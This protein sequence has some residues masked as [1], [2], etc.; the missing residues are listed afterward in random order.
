MQTRKVDFYPKDQSERLALVKKVAEVVNKVLRFET[1][2]DVKPNNVFAKAAHT[3]IFPSEVEYEDVIIIGDD[4][5][6]TCQSTKNDDLSML[7]PD[8][9]S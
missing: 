7:N 2:F 1:H 4:F 9:R 5:D 6:Y 3:S 8:Y